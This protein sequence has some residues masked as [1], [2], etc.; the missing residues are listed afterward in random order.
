[1]RITNLQIRNRE[2]KNLDID[3]N[4]NTSGVMAFIGNNGSGK[5]NIL[6]SLCIIFYFLYNRKEKEI[7]F[8]F[9]ITYT[10]SG[11]SIPIKIT[12]NKTTVI[13]YDGDKMISDPYAYLPKQIVAI[14]SG[15][16][17]RLWKKWFFPVYLDYINN[18]T[19]GKSTGI[20]VFN[21]LPKMLFINKFYW[22]LSLL[23]LLLQQNYNKDDSFCND[24]LNIKKVHSIKFKFNKE[25]YKN[26]PESSVKAF[27]QL[28]DSKDEY[29]LNELVQVIDKTVFDVSDIYKFLY[30]AFT[31]DKKKI[32]EKI[33]IKYN[34]EN[35]EI[36]DFSEGEKKMLLIKAALEFAGAEDSLFILDEPDAH[37]HLSNKIQ[38]KNLF[39]K[40]ADHRQVIITTHSP[41][42]TD[43]LQED[44]LYMLNS[45]KLVTQIKQEILENVSGEYWNKMQQNAFVA[46]RKPIILLVEGKHDKEHIT[47]AYE[48]LKEDYKDLDF[49]IFKLNT[50]TNIQ[51]FLRGLYESEF[52]NSKIYVGLFDRE[53]K[54]LK[55][56]KNPKSYT[57]IDS[58]IFYKILESDK[59]NTNYYATTLPEIEAKKCD[60]SIEMMYEYSKWEEAYQTAVQNTV[61]KTTNK[62]IKKYSDDVLN[63]AK[64]I[65]SENSKSFFKNDFENFRK[66]FDLIREIKK[67]CD[68]NKVAVVKPIVIKPAPVNPN[69]SI[70]TP[71]VSAKDNHLAY[72]TA[73]K[74]FVAQQ[75]VSFKLQSPAPQH[76]SYVSIGSTIFKISILANTKNK[77]LCIQ[78]LCR[79]ADV[80]KDFKKLR[81][82]YEADAKKNLNPDLEWK[83]NKGR[84]EHHINLVFADN[85]PFDKTQWNNQHQLLSDW[86]E[87]FY[88]YFKDKI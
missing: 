14:Y 11:R 31:P 51:P 74:A 6:E 63:D 8:N 2:Y 45:G 73:F 53:E 68:E 79:G 13:T 80:L 69:I 77:S 54:I 82:K 38:I 21:E 32:L 70:S 65:L 86:T 23:C 52:D 22:D 75:Q 26:Y 49:E 40:Y 88:K 1:M 33:T 58:K 20:G 81:A 46:S 15:E 47:S 3:L 28:I 41:T 84:K 10:N 35:L 36:E 59:P 24:T 34:D 42:L 57:N 71:K 18:I 19:S 60:C 5:S 85:N 25:N 76:W 62:S 16:E 55:D 83:E 9:S 17:D 27:I 37:I 64:N 44:S 48:A 39:E 4:N 67:Y 87:K 30:I 66:L 29:I 72:W 50:E 61:G 12:K 43:S 78:L 7:P 56:L